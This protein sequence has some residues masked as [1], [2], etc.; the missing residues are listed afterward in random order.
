MDSKFKNLM[1]L[2]QDE[3]TQF[4]VLSQELSSVLPHLEKNEQ[5]R[6]FAK[7]TF[8]PLRKEWLRKKVSFN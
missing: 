5:D 2:L 8:H 3:K 4:Q 1:R 7:T 6:V